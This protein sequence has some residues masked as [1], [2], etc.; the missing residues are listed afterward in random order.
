MVRRPFQKKMNPNYP[1]MHD[2]SGFDAFEGYVEEWPG[3]YVPPEHKKKPPEIIEQLSRR[4][5]YTPDF[6][7]LR[8]KDN[9]LVF[10]YD[11]FRIRG[12][13]NS[14]FN[15]SKYLGYGISA[16]DLYCL[17]G[18]TLP[19][20]LDDNLKSSKIRGRIKGE[21]Y[22][23]PPETLLRLDKLKYNTVLFKRVERTFFLTDQSYKT[24]DGSRIPSLK[25][26]VYI[27][28]PEQWQGDHL[29]VQPMFSHA[30]SKERK[31]FEYF[32]KDAYNSYN[33]VG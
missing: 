32:P 8:F 28:K 19:V 11:E 17:K 6:N 1:G 30:G 4:E 24:K 10:M 21:I 25:A 33:H 12:K 14:I 26:W 15:D 22:A 9:I 5:K 16:T 27:G 7:K 13:Q 2:Q 23:V 29:S 20:L 18:H 31:Y 3:V